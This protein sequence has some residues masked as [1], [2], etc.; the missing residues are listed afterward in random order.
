MQQPGHVVLQAM[1]QL[2]SS[3]AIPVLAWPIWLKARTQVVRAKVVA[4]IVVPAV[5]VA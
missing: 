5:R 2:S 4:C 3:E 1:W